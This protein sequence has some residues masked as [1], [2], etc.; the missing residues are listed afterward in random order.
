MKKSRTEFIVQLCW[1]LLE[2]QEAVDNY[3]GDDMITWSALRIPLRQTKHS[4]LEML[5]LDEMAE[6]FDEDAT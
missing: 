4:L 2:E 6:D 1:H 3:D 5:K